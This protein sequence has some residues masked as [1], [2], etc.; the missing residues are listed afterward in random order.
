MPMR[1]YTYTMEIHASLSVDN[2]DI[3][4]Y[5]QTPFL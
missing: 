4:L 2:V 3:L 1:Y 5:Y